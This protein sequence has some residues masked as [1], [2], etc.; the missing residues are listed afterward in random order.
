MSDPAYVVRWPHEGARKA[1]SVRGTYR[2]SENAQ[3]L[4]RVADGAEIF[5]GGIGYGHE[6]ED[7]LLG[8]DLDDFVDELNRVAAQRDALFAACE[9]LHDAILAQVGPLSAQSKRAEMKTALD[10]IWRVND[11]VRAAIAAAKAGV[12]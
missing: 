2:E 3:W 9:A 1:P 12:R 8:R 4:E 10:E 5:Y 11:S 6:P 7:L